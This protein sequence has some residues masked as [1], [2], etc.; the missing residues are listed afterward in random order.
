MAVMIVDVH[1]IMYGA[2]DDVENGLVSVYTRECHP[3]I[4]SLSKI[5]RRYSSAVSF[6]FPTLN[7][8]LSGE[9]LHTLLPECAL[10]SSWNAQPEGQKA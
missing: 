5:L 7:T 1:G 3:N 6:P 8:S 9:S 2:W 4:I 10:R